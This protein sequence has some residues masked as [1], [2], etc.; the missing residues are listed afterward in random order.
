MC[1]PVYLEDGTL[2]ERAQEKTFPTRMVAMAN[3]SFVFELL[4][5]VQYVVSIQFCKRE[6]VEKAN[7]AVSTIFFSVL[8]YMP[9]HKLIRM[10]T[11]S[12]IS[13]FNELEMNKIIKFAASVIRTSTICNILYA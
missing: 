10:K 5:T 13:L 2:L 1:V 9:R 12:I 8:V 6:A 11:I 7:W 3:L 4:N